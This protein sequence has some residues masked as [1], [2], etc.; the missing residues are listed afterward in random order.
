[1]EERVVLEEVVEDTVLEEVVLELVE[2]EEVQ[3]APK[4]LAM[5]TLM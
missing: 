1:M 5:S 3:G 4:K 2:E